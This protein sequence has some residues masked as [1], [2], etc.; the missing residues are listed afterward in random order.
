MNKIEFSVLLAVYDQE[1]PE[2][3]D[4][5]LESI[6]SKQTLKPTEIVIVKDGP[7]TKELEQVIKEF[8]LIAPVKTVPIAVNGGLGKALSKGV[9]ECSYEIIAR[10]DSD[11]ISAP[12]RFKKQV[13]IFVEKKLD[14]VSSWSI[15]FENSLENV[16]ATKKRPEFDSEIKILAK[17]RSPVNHAACI[18]RKSTV[19]KAGNYRHF[20]LY[21]DYDLWVRM[22]MKNAVFYNVQDYVYYVRGSN[23]QFGRRGGLKYLLTEIKAHNNFRKYGFL[24]SFEFLRNIL[25]RVLVRLF[26][27]KI[28]RWIY[29][30]IWKTT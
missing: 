14:V 30:I 5:A 3:L 18:L 13:P 10:M 12:D 27:V 29:K 17:K 24:N 26:P 1:K 21:E 7:L 6:W 16:L 8:S 28:R 22:I 15:F 25:I 11:D 4:L 9:N 20:P 2:Y 23:E 19:L